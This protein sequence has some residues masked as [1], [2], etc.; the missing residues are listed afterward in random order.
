VALLVESATFYSLANISETFFEYMTREWEANLLA[1]FMLI[2]LYVAIMYADKWIYISYKKYI[3]RSLKIGIP[4]SIAILLIDW[5][6]LEVRGG[7]DLGDLGFVL[8]YTPAM[9]ALILIFNSI[10]YSLF[11]GKRKSLKITTL[12]NVV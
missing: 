9:V 12:P 10:L 2:P 11:T 4:S 1:V 3:W 7:G 8:F 5:A 6:H